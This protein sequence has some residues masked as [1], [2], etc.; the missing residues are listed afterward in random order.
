MEA[1]ELSKRDQDL[2]NAYN[3]ALEQAS[4]PFLLCEVIQK[5]ISMPAKQFYCAVRGVYETIREIE[6]GQRPTFSCPERERLV[7]DIYE[8]V[9]VLRLKKPDVHLKH[10]VEEVIDS[11]APEFYLKETSAIVILHHIKKQAKVN[12]IIKNISRN[13]RIE[14]RKNRQ[15]GLI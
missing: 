1:R 9:I 6:R 5:A 3:S 7:M 11:P 4:Y 2:L 12:E 13:E 15:R 14:R 10:I 8:K